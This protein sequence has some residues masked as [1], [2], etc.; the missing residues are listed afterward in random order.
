MI[1]TI[2]TLYFDSGL[3]DFDH[4]SRS[5]KCKKAKKSGAVIYITKLWINLE[6]LG[7]LLRLVVTMNLIFISSH[8]VNIQ[9]REPYFCDFVLV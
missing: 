8:P 6:E 9:G 3:T 1:D 4:D 2:W 5:Q 7:V